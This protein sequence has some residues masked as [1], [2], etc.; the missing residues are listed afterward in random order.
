MCL[1]ATRLKFAEK[2]AFA[3]NSGLWLNILRWVHTV[4]S[5]ALRWRYVLS[6]LRGATCFNRFG[7]V[8]FPQTNSVCQSANQIWCASQRTKYGLPVSEPNMVCQ[9]ANQIWFA[10]QP[11]RLFAIASSTTFIIVNYGRQWVQAVITFWNYFCSAYTRLFWR[12]PYTVGTEF[13]LR[14]GWHNFI[15]QITCAWPY[16]SLL[17]AVWEVVRAW[18]EGTEN[19]T[20]RRWWTLSWG[21]DFRNDF[22]V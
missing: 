5:G 11:F 21:G 10:S 22:N 14:H 7:W 3:K 16:K 2:N 4:L 20:T 18:L 17:K 9:S 15:F 12:Y 8:R 19:T 1:T 6:P 13:L